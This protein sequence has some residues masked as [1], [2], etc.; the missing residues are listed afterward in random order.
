MSPRDIGSERK[1]AQ[2]APKWASA[3]I[4]CNVLSHESRTK[5]S[6]IDFGMDCF[7][8]FD[9][10]NKVLRAA[11]ALQQQQQPPKPPRSVMAPPLLRPSRA[12]GCPEAGQT[13]RTFVCRR[14]P[15]VYFARIQEQVPID[16][17]II[18][19]IFKYLTIN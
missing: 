5:S 6:E 4:L 8:S 2:G 17:R 10:S 14:V 13:S 3:A 1:L 18:L 11:E 19:N 12:D 15:Q 7:N 9:I 16:I